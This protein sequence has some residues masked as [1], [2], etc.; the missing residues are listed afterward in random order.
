MFVT[1][2]L[3]V[4]IMLNGQEMTSHQKSR[5]PIYGPQTCEQIVDKFVENS[6]TKA[7]Q[8]MEYLGYKVEIISVQT[9]NN[10]KDLHG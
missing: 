8:H 2:L 3:S 6:L 4:T 9:Q 5:V 7:V 10:C 1:V